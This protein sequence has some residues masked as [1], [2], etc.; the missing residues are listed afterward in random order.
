MLV[1]YAVVLLCFKLLPHSVISTVSPQIIKINGVKWIL[2][3]TDMQRM[4][5]R[6]KLN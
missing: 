1:F 2:K 4:T 5:A 6:F 3:P